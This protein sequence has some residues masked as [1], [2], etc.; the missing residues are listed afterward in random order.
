MYKIKKISTN[1]RKTVGKYTF[2]IQKM[3]TMH[4]IF[5]DYT[6]VRSILLLFKINL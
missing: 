5:A 2:C 1:K 4:V 3:M 6:C